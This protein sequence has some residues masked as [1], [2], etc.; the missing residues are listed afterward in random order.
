MYVSVFSILLNS[1]ITQIQ[2][3][4]G[5]HFLQHLLVYNSYSPKTNERLPDDSPNVVVPITQKN[6]VAMKKKSFGHNC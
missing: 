1:E 2:S 4:N 3:S 6:Q 5:K